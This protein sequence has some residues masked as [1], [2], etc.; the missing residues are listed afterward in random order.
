[1]KLKNI[2]ENLE[3]PLND[4]MIKYLYDN[5]GY[6][7]TYDL[8]IGSN[9]KPNTTYDNNQRDSYNKLLFNIWRNSILNLSKERVEEL[10]K[11]Y[12]YKDIRRIQ[13]VLSWPLSKYYDLES[14]DGIYRCLVSENMDLA[15]FCLPENIKNN[16][17]KHTV[18]DKIV[19]TEDEYFLNHPINHR[20]YVNIDNKNIYKLVEKVVEKCNEKELPFYFKFEDNFNRKDSFVL[21]TDTK[22]LTNYMECLDEVFEE[23]KDLRMSTYPPLMFAGQVSPYYSIGDQ[24]IQNSN[25]HSFNTL[26]ASSIDNAMMNTIRRWMYENQN[27]KLKRKGEVLEF[28]DYLTDK[29]IGMLARD[30]YGEQKYKNYYNLDDSVFLDKNFLVEKEIWGGS[31]ERNRRAGTENLQGILGLGIALEETYKILHEE[32]GKEEK[33]HNYM[34]SR[35]KNE[36][37]DIKINGEKASRIKTITNVCI[38]GCDVQTLL[39]ALDLRGICVSGGSACM[40]GAHENSHVLKEMGLSEEELKSSF[41]ISIGKYTTMEEIDY[42]IDNLKEIVKIERE[43]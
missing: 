30:I 42:F 35:L 17:F 28:K 37:E 22:N 18:S 4:S 3:N 7:D 24:P 26:R 2:Y 12:N 33:L 31:Q 10:E 38:K 34:E 41:R 25:L 29:V 19:L 1:M 8:V 39:I 32:K 16:K 43:E 11:R 40:S 5:Y 36:I 9:T 15:Y 13:S 6:V 21:Y 27:T 14:T 23:N 20:L